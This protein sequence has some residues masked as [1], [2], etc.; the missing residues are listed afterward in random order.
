MKR[1]LHLE[2]GDCRD[3]PFLSLL[4]GAKHCTKAVHTNWLCAII[5]K[6]VKIP[7]WCPLP[8]KRGK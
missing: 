5:P 6:D 8:V 4:A 2:I 1:I 7:E 3:C